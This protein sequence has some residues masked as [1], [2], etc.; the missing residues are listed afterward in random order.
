[1]T[2]VNLPPAIAERRLDLARQAEGCRT[3]AQ[4]HERHA[5]S[6]YGRAD[7]CQAEIDG[8]DATAK[9]FADFLASATYERLTTEQ[10]ALPPSV[11]IMPPPPPISTT[12]ERQRAPRY[13]A[14]IFQAVR[15]ADHPLTSQQVADTAKCSLSHAESVLDYHKE[16]GNLRKAGDLWSCVFVVGDAEGVRYDG[17][18]I[19]AITPASQSNGP[20]WAQPD[21][22]QNGGGVNLNHESGY[23]PGPETATDTSAPE[24]ETFP[25]VVRVIKEAGPSG[26][27]DEDLA[28]QGYAF[29]SVLR[30]AK[31]GYVFNREKHYIAI[32]YQD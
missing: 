30:A 24:A 10:A 29:I 18:A 1:M 4:E 27:T 9:A 6:M 17:P 13:A 12:S 26:L 8:I 3:E 5:A 31:A 11:P 22:Q 32:E 16:L 21:Q 23:Q 20:S 14:A 28:R 2:D 7:R 25:D 15:D 19:E